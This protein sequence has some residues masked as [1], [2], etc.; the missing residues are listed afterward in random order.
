MFAEVFSIADFSTNYCNVRNL[1]CGKEDG[2]VTVKHSF[3][4]EELKAA[5]VITSTSLPKS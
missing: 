3:A 4:T 1:Y 2:C 5:Y